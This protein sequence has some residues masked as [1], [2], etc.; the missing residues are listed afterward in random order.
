MKPSSPVTGNLIKKTEAFG[1]KGCLIALSN[2]PFEDGKFVN[3]PVVSAS[4]LLEEEFAEPFGSKV[5]GNTESI[6]TM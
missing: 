5:A 4:L 1:L 2:A 6:C 3:L